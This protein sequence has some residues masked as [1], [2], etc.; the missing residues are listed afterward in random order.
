M[1]LSAIAAMAAN[2]VIGKDGGLPWKIPEDT[3]FFRDKTM[4]SVM[5]MGR[6]TF[7]SFGGKPLPGR[8]HVVITR[9]RDITFEG[10]HVVHTV[11]EA[12]KFCRKLVSPTTGEAPP[13]WKDE[14]FIVGGGEIYREMLPVTDRIYLTEIHRDFSGEARFPEF[15]TLDFKEV[16]REARMEPVPYDFVVYER[17]RR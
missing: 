11:D 9:Q 6:K 5:I 4:G 16:S 2:R 13:K 3:K 10:A 8:L 17:R 1:I 12:V 15:S 7:D 14:V